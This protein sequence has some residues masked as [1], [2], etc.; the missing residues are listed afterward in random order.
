M[1]ELHIGESKNYI[2]DNPKWI[3]VHK[4]ISFENNIQ[5]W[6]GSLLYKLGIYPQQTVL[7]S[8]WDS[9]ETAAEYLKQKESLLT[10]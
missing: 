2:F 5:G 10:K 9:N 4:N 3:I 1:T 6:W 8:S 7:F